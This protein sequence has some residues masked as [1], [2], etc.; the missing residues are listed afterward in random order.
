M[1]TPNTHTHT[2][3]PTRGVEEERGVV[4]GGLAEALKVNIFEQRSISNSEQ[5]IKP[6]LKTAE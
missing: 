5:M 6:V 1:H 3:T 2:H 4:T